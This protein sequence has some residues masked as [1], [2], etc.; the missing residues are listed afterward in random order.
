MVIL[1]RKTTA[2]TYLVR[3]EHGRQSVRWQ[4]PLR[5]NHEG[6]CG[7]EERGHGR[8]FG[9]IGAQA[10]EHEVRRQHVALD[11]SCDGFNSTGVWQAECLPSVGKR[12]VDIFHSVRY[13]IVG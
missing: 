10:G 13:R 1:S 3:A 11:L 2:A 12:G 9:Q 6:M 8:H 5:A 4:V 7:T